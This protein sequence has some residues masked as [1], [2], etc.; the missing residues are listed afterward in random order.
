MLRVF[1]EISDEDTGR[2][3]TDKKIWQCGEEYRAYQGKFPVIFLT[4]K[5]VKFATWE[6]TI[7]KIS[8]LLQEEY[9]R[10]KEVMHSDQLKKNILHEF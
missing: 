8:A 3:F 10:H 5:D 2:Y 7:D 4:F 1:F 6:N 9:D